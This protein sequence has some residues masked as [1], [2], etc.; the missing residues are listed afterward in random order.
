MDQAKKLASD[1]TMSLAAAV[2]ELQRTN[3]DLHA[4]YLKEIA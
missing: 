3:P 1:K 4:A 2:R